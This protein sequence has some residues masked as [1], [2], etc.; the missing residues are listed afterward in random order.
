MLLTESRTPEQIASLQN[1]QDNIKAV[2]KKL[3]AANIKFKENGSTALDIYND[4]SKVHPI[5]TVT[6]EKEN[7]FKI[8][9]SSAE[10]MALTKNYYSLKNGAAYE[11][12]FVSDLYTRSDRGY[13]K[14][15]TNTARPGV[16]QISTIKTVDFTNDLVQK[17]RQ[18]RGSV[19]LVNTRNV[20]YSA[21]LQKYLI[22][23]MHHDTETDEWTLASITYVDNGKVAEIHRTKK[24]RDMWLA[25]KRAWY[26]GNELTN[27]DEIINFISNFIIDTIGSTTV[28]AAEKGGKQKYLISPMLTLYKDISV[29]QDDVESNVNI[30]SNDNVERPYIRFTP[31]IA[32][33][34]YNGITIEVRISKS[35]EKDKSIVIINDVS[36]TMLF[37]NMKANLADI[38]NANYKKEIAAYEQDINGKL[39]TIYD[40]V[41]SYVDDYVTSIESDLE[42]A[43][44]IKAQA[45]EFSNHANAVKA[46]QAAADRE[47]EASEI[48]KAKSMQ[49]VY[50][51][52]DLR[53]RQ[54]AAEEYQKKAV[55]REERSAQRNAAKEE[56][57]NQRLAALRAAKVKD[58]VTDDDI[59]AA[60]R[61]LGI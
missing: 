24:N 6:A 33:K 60:L 26:R 47:R 32:D 39:N 19:S 20:V 23:H 41:M 55:E 38:N 5:Y 18:M 43:N 50:D 17:R 2:A 25:Y 40:N 29:N 46:A 8:V 51:A 3:S 53:K 34:S 15:L 52:E 48:A 27:A 45:T 37:T 9:D 12:E 61:E 31:V 10:R 36:N 58:E 21:A 16:N 56:R 59:E 42:H 30:V 49:S 54:Q 57:M 13:N 44:S 11:P 1:K 35:S 22:G 14:T 28:N 7:Q 4:V